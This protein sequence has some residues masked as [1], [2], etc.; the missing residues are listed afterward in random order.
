MKKLLRF[1]YILA[2]LSGVLFVLPLVSKHLSLIAWVSLVPLFYALESMPRH[3]FRTGLIFGI[4]A[5]YVGQY[6]MV[7]TLTRFGGF[8]I[9]VSFI[10]I[11]V[12][13]LYLGIQYALFTYLIDK[14]KL[15]Q[16]R[17]VSVLNVFVI[18]FLW[19]VLEHFYPVLF[20][21][22]LGNTQAYNLRVIQISDLLGVSFLS[23][24]IVFFNLTVYSI[25]RSVFQ[26]GKKP[27]FEVVLSIALIVLL[28]IYGSVRINQEII[29]VSKA[30]KITIGVV[31]ANFDFF[32][33]TEQN[34]RS[35]IEEH[36]KMSMTINNADLIIWPETSL[37]KWIDVR[38]EYLNFPEEE[39]TIPEIEGTYFLL[40]G[41]SYMIEPSEENEGDFVF[42]Q[43]N[44]AFLA[45]WNG[46]ILD[47]YDKVQLL[48]FGEYLPLSDLMPWIKYLSPVSGD[49]TPGTE[50][51]VLNISDKGIKIGPL[52]CYED[53]I[54]SFSRNFSIKGVNILINLTNDAWFGRSI[55][56]Y[57][58]LLVSIPRAVETR[59][60]LI[61]STN[62]GVSAIINSI[63]EV[64]NETEIFKKEVFVDSV[65][66]LYSDT[67]YM[68]V[69]DIFPFLCLISFV[70][71]VFNKY[72]RKRYS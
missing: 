58:H 6:W 2:A 62:T 52:I 60:Y 69:G 7:E 59:R 19:I 4:V 23:F 15:I 14:I 16:N 30:E 70:L 50:L 43:Y 39:K 68:K 22:G 31:Q 36:K 21:Y 5:N 32:E 25:A 45:D 46:K 1:E 34:S 48:L 24:I 40:G 12:Y 41:L 72:L 49:F 42:T 63:G 53:I 51:N 3:S 29:N 20:P 44:S 65:A 33:K 71:F 13:C 57:Q 54:P 11:L 55:A 47:K 37:Q 35:I 56:P 27:L 67:V 18:C 66:L 61:R 17:S 26:K 38:A 28:I 10:F 8:P 9:A 64:T